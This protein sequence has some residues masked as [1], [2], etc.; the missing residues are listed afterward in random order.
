MNMKISISTLLLVV[1]TGCVH[2]VR[3]APD[4]SVPV[5]TCVMVTA[6]GKTV[7]YRAIAGRCLSTNALLRKMKQGLAEALT[8]LKDEASEIKP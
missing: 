5:N 8:E 4:A 2:R 6:V 7:T 1:L 3:V